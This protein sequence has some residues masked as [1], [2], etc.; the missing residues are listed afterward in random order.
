M[1]VVKW[2]KF[3]RTL[4]Y[5]RYISLISCFYNSLY[6]YPE[7]KWPYEIKKKKWLTIDI[8][9]KGIIYRLEVP[10]GPLLIGRSNDG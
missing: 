6:W 4:G 1:S 5:S 2:Y 8:L 7:G 9:P 3:L 10:N